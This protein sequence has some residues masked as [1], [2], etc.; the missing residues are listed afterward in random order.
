[1]SQE[2]YE[3]PKQAFSQGD[4]I[5]VAPH[6]FLDPPL[7]ALHGA[8]NGLY[9]VEEDPFTKFDDTAG[10][11]VMARCKRARAIVLTHDCEI[12]KPQIVR[13]HLCP[14][15]PLYK[16]K[17]DNQ[18]K[19]KRNRIYSMFFLPQYGDI[20]IDSFV[21]FNQISTV[22]RDFI[23]SGKRLLSLSDFGRQGLYAQFFRWLSRFEMREL[24][25]PNCRVKFNPLDSV[26]R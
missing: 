2:L 9:K 6:I 15:V 7:R 22:G 4:I 8:E 24:E 5:D 14:V 19:V 23:K 13:W 1:M 17:P 25:C 21:D 10:Q 11:D 20:L 18:D 16:L 26:V 12:D 3:Q